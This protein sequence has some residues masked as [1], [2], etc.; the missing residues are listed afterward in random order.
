MRLLPLLFIFFL[1]ACSTYSEED[2]ITFDQK[3]KHWIKQQDT[4]FNK[5]ESGLYFSFEKTGYGRNIKYTDSVSVIFTGYL[6]DGTI[7]EVEKKPISFAVKEVITAWKEILLM[8]KNKAKVQIITPP[9]L[10]YGNY[11]LETIPQNAILIYKIEIVDI[12]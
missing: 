10:G 4:P 11:K 3:I 2:L 7:F 6:L 5:T 8:S 12:N 9:Q 1:G